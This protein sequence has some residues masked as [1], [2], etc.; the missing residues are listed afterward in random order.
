MSAGRA[1]LLVRNPLDIIV[2]QFMMAVTLTHSRSVSNDF[3]VEFAAEWQWLVKAQA[4][5]WNQFFQYW[6]ELAKSK[7]IPVHI[8]RFEDLLTKKREII[9]GTFEFLLGV[10]KTE[11]LY[12]GKRIDD[13]LA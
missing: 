3:P 8:I 9:T 6:I 13:V 2:S 1:V 11:G 5:L 7:K 10:E 4:V 12:I